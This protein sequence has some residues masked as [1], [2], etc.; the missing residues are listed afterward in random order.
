MT[1]TVDTLPSKRVAI[2]DTHRNEITLAKITLPVILLFSASAMIY[3]LVLGVPSSPEA[4]TYSSMFKSV[5]IALQ[6]M[7]LF[8]VFTIGLRY[9]MK[10]NF[11]VRE[12]DFK[13]EYEAIRLHLVATPVML[14]LGV[15][16][17]AAFILAFVTFKVRI[18]YVHPF[19]L[20]QAIATIDA[21]IFGGRQ[22]W[23]YFR[24]MYDMPYIIP[25][26]DFL[27]TVWVMLVKACWVY[28]FV[29]FFDTI[30]RR[31]Q[32]ILAY[33]S[34]W[35]IGGVVLATLLSSGGPCYYGYLVD[36]PDIF[37]EQLTLL[38]QFNLGA[39]A[40]HDVLWFDYDRPGVGRLG[41]SAMPSMHCASALLIALMFSQSRLMK[42]LTWSFFAVIFLGS[43]LLAWHYA[44]DGIIGALVAFAC[45]R[46]A[47]WAAPRL[48]KRFESSPA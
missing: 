4:Q 13:R 48:I 32:F 31:V 1:T 45:W 34:T 47:G 30:E 41:I 12:E 8:F 27:Y 15:A 20:D 29:A 36:G 44:A 17:F 18:P 23:E 6:T 37:A 19:D 5:V 39:V 24:W 43:F 2:L 22:A 7:L 11:R 3:S 33:T 38:K 14:I 21:T 16:T 10:Y 26:I 25:A 28:A 9:L 35:F 42:I 46:G 40:Y